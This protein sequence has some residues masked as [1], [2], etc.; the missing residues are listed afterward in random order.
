M[1]K[2]F[3]VLVVAFLGF[4][5]SCSK[6]SPENEAK[7]LM[8]ATI[9]LTDSTSEKLEKAATAQDAAAALV[10][11]VAEM[12]V[13]MEKGKEYAKNHPGVSYMEDESN[14]AENEAM[15]KAMYRFSAASM[16]ASA[17]FSG[18]KE[19]ADAAAKMQ[20]IMQ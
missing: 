17:K 20:D 6:A 4:A 3:A 5:I 12:K 18:S 8:N 7:A 9:K 1:K 19:F 15:D 16:K 11:Y 10:T 2:F 14:K 13:L